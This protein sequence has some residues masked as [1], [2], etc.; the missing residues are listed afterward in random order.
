[1]TSSTSLLPSIV[2]ARVVHRRTGPIAHA[3]AYRTCTWLIDI[4]HPPRLPAPLRPFARFRAGDHFP[5]PYAPG[6]TLRTRLE[7]HLRAIGVEPANGPVTAL[8][9]PRVAG[10]VFNPLSVFWC[11]RH[12]GALA[13]VVAEVH[14]TYGGRHCYVVGVD[15]SGRALADKDFYVSPFN[16]VSGRYRL[17]VPEPA[18]DGRVR[19]SIVLE[20]AETG[21]F[22]AALTG[23]ARPATARR[24]LL[25]QV[26]TPLAPWVVAARIR[27][28]GIRLWRRG[29]P[30]VPRPAQDRPMT[31]D[32]EHRND[33]DRT[34]KDGRSGHER[35]R[36]L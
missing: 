35:T 4:D 11:H 2:G 27:L 33:D 9:S 22:F 10:Y 8:M 34:R 15:P 36:R 26:T 18:A 25:A 14:N 12:D 30:I 16:D 32:T 6:Q 29:L 24:V 7:H 23:R 21:P 20:R 1:M 19:I 17:S 28:Q 13:H 3:F 5:E 31:A